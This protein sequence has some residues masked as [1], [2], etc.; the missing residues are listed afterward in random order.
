[1]A[2]DE[3]EVVEPGGDV[4]YVSGRGSGVAGGVSFEPEDILVFDFNTG[5]WSIFID[6]SDIGLAGNDIGAFVVQSD[7]SIL[8][9]LDDP[10]SVTGVVGTVDDSDVLLLTPTATGDDTAGDF[11]ADPRR[12]RCGPVHQQ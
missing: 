1:M 6:G 11:F 3:T 10:Q 12:L 4:I 8:L 5:S 9:N 7:G 2:T